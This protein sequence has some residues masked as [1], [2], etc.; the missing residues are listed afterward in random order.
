[1]PDIDPVLLQLER[2]LRTRAD[3]DGPA[4]F[5]IH[6]LP[7]KRQ[8][9]EPHAY[10]V[11]EGIAPN[12]YCSFI[13]SGLAFRQKVTVAGLR[14][15][16]S[17]HMAGDFINLQHLYLNFSDHSVQAL[18]QVDVVSIN[19]ADLRNLVPAHHGIAQALWVDALID[20]SVF[21]E[22]IVN[23]GRRNA[24]TRVAHLICEVATRMQMAGLS[25]LDGFNLPMSQE[26]IGDAVGLTSIHVNR[27]LKTLTAEGYITRENRYITITDWQR[28]CHVAQFRSLY[29]FT[30]QA[31]QI[32]HNDKPGDALTH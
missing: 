31:A 6:N 22:W 2:K 19:R 11:K 15:I 32:R 3:L 1:M 29:L 9:F 30:D 28:L 21:R 13:I 17:I 14:Q 12:D 7:Y 10:L 20:G 4:E 5:A 24:R 18:T 8:T 25:G 27:T 23:V 26:Q 16:V